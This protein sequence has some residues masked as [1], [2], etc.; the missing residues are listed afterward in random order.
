MKHPTTA[1]TR[2][3]FPVVVLA[4]DERPRRVMTDFEAMGIAVVRGRAFDDADRIAAAETVVISAE[5]ERLAFGGASGVGRKLLMDDYPMDVIGV[6]ANVRQRGFTDE[7]LVALYGLVWRD[8]ARYLVVRAGGDAAALLPMIRQTVENDDAR[9]FVTSIERL[10]DLV[11]RSIVLQRGRAMLSGT[12]GLAALLLAS[13][14][15]YGLAARLVA[16]RRREIGIRIALGA[17]P[18]DVRRLVMADAWLIVGAGLVI[19]VPGAI[20]MS[21]LAEGL[22]YG[23]APAAPHVLILVVVA[24]AMAAMVSTL[25][26]AL[27]ANR[28][29]P[30]V[31]LRE[32]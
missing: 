21:R 31:A 7:D 18:R 10:D 13:V 2:P 1:S 14:G 16:E 28:V 25:I 20:G 19:G 32:E 26:P 24:L 12:Y 30:A 8:S 6:V 5:L 27:R 23:V 9:M 22:L 17:G 15:L 29:D 4:D 11:A 3:C